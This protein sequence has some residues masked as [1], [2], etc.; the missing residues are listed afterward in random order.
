MGLFN[1]KNTQ[2]IHPHPHPSETY[3][4]PPPQVSPN[5]VRHFYTRNYKMGDYN[6]NYTTSYDTTFRD[7]IKYYS[8]EYGLAPRYI[9][10]PQQDFVV[11]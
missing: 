2:K 3:T 4:H 1:S 8:Q 9:D 10:D 11:H 6:N 5:D 7:N